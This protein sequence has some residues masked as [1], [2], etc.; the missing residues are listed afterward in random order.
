[1]IVVAGTV[2]VRPDQREAAIRAA[3]A[4]AEATN[5]EQ[6]CISYRFATDLADP[7]TV[8]IFEEWE[9]D[10]A[11]ARHFQTEHMRVF[12]AEI[13]RFVAGPASIKRY[14]VESASPMT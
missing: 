10:E 7:N 4:M 13:P 2:P 8:L 3:L 12:Q 1:M 11:L 6:G 5:K 14:V 9:S